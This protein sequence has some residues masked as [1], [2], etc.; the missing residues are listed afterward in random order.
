[1]RKI[2]PCFIALVTMMAAC[3]TA[4]GCTTIAVGGGATGD[5]SVIVS[6]SN[7]AL[8]D[9]RVVRVPAADHPKGSSRN[10]YYEQPACGYLPEYG[11][12]RFRNYVG[13][14]R[15]PVYD[16][17]ETPSRPI[18]TI[19]QVEH[20]YAY[21]ESVYGIMNEHQLSI[22]ETTCRA[23]ADDIKPEP[24]KRIF[25]SSSLA[26][27]ALE[28]CRK[29][30]EAVELIGS[31]IDRYGYYGTGE[32]LVLA[33]PKEAWVVEM[34]GY[35]PDAADGLWAAQ[36]VPDDGVFVSAN[37]F[38]IREI[39][40]NS[41]DMIYSSNLFALCEKMGWWK[42]ED[43][44]LDWATTVGAGEYHHPYYS[45]RRVWRVLSRVKPS[46]GFSPYVNNAFTKA[47]PFTVT[48]D[49][50]LSVR[51]ILSLH[52]DHYEGTDF[53]LT[54]GPAARPFGNPTRYEMAS[55]EADAQEN[56]KIRGAFERPLSVY[57]C[58]YTM[59]TQSR[60]WL[61][62][63][64]GG[65]FWIGFDKPAE[66]CFMPI[67][68]GVTTMPP[69]FVRGTTVEYDRESAWWAFNVVANCATIKYSYMITDIKILQQKF[70][71]DEFGRQREIEESAA[72]HWKKG[73]EKQCRESLTAYCTENA[74]QVVT[75][76][77]Q[78]WE[79]LMVK[80]NDGYLVGENGEKNK[81]GYPVPWLRD[82]GY[83]NGP[84]KYG[85]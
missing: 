60:S 40:K 42:P 21:F 44:A 81:I 59:V 23:K 30:R 17:G 32:C 27:V 70:E 78:L 68:A 72:A 45:L 18:G 55:G 26:R 5:G 28:R 8:R 74:A 13:K 10:V 2:F 62:D 67:Y 35:D 9:A 79:Q 19:P 47:Y 41:P 71:D 11:G 77:K 76:W 22:G 20:T 50:P 48:P 61:P 36:R 73:E 75:S 46:A 54:K 16:T 33:D 38:R 69:S 57:R 1:M 63:P 25:Y 43:G 85:R 15:G 58:G 66:S 6:H 14:D 52:R 3:D 83:E 34:C 80:Y 56:S 82:V 84:T 37:Q 65:V 24:G 31:L 39:K 64:V 4:F 49:R 53:D 51:D 7:D 12:V 29:A